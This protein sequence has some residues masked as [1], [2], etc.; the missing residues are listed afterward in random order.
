[1]GGGLAGDDGLMLSESSCNIS[2]A[3]SK[4]DEQQD[5]VVFRMYIM[6]LGTWASKGL[7]IAG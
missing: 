3:V 2:M 5:K 7:K 1:M 4:K 6:N